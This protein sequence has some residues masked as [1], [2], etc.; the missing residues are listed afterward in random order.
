MSHS[1]FWTPIPASWFRRIRIN[2]RANY[3]N[4]DYDVRHYI[5][6][7]FVLTDM[8]RH[9]GFHW[10]PN[11]VFGGWTLSSNWFFRTGLPF[12]VIDERRPGRVGRLRLRC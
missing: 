8:F 10:G 3:G 5:S 4:S 2:V 11:R 6:A 1:A 7:T 9:A 12:T